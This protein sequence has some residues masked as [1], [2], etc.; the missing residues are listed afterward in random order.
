[1]YKRSSVLY[2]KMKPSKWQNEKI[3][4]IFNSRVEIGRIKEWKNLYTSQL[5]FSELDWIDEVYFSFLYLIT[6]DQKQPQME[7]WDV[8]RLRRDDGY[9]QSELH[10]SDNLSHRCREWMCNLKP[11]V[12]LQNPFEESVWPV[13][14]LCRPK[15]YHLYRV[16]SCVV[17]G[18]IQVPKLHWRDSYSLFCLCCCVCFQWIKVWEFDEAVE[19]F[20]QI[21]S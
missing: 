7:S 17:V 15:L 14:A 4:R 9:R 1:M 12:D 8:D 5:W 21:M 3:S 2:I 19:V 11:Q 10:W 20:I 16:V 6:M 13:T 18:T